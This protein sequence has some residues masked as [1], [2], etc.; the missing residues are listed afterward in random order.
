MSL[1]C[2]Q[3]KDMEPLVTALTEEEEDQ[4]KNMLHRIDTIVRVSTI[5]VPY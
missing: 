3:T 4:M 2:C 1:V 5:Q